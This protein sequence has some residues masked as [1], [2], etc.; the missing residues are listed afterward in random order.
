MR[1]RF[2]WILAVAALIA[3]AAMLAC[4]TKYAASNNGLVVVSTQGNAVMDTFSLNLNNGSVSEINN[5]NGPPINGVGTSVVLDP[6]GAYAY[7]LVAQSTF[8]NNSETG[9]EAFAIASDGKLGSGTTT[10]LKGGVL[11]VAMAIDSSGKFLFIADSSPGAVSVLS[12]GSGGALTEIPNSPFLLPTQIGGPIPSAS[13]VA[14]SSTKY[15]PAYAICS[16]NVPP[17]TENLY[18]TDAT[19]YYVLNYSVASSG[20]LT[21][22]SQNV[23][24][25][26]PAGVTVD[27]CN[28]FVYVSNS[29]GNSVSAFT[30]CNTVTLP[31][32]TLAD[33]S[34]LPVNGSPFNTSPGAGPG[35]LMMDAYANYLYVLDSSG[36]T[37]GTGGISAFAVSSVSGSLTALS[38]PLINTNSYPTSMAIRSDDS[39]LFVANSDSANL[40]EYAITPSNGK[41]VPQTA[42]QTDNTPWG[43][44]VK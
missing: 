39:W 8:V 22:V 11:P 30:I 6:A 25:T 36:S 43:V 3:A 16:A 21:F 12:I 9:V 15:P 18:V 7:V 41:L 26:D 33:F 5:V 10:V 28:R 24:G 38:P 13:A 17:A 19:S 23:T 35:P 32:C 20:V 42:V 4:S 31:N 34:L 40:S 1:I 29:L 44:A 2:P 37:A 27:P 14:V